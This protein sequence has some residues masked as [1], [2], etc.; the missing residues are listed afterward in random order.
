MVNKG[1][2]LGKKQTRLGKSLRWS[3]QKLCRLVRRHVAGRITWRRLRGNYSNKHAG[4]WHLILDASQRG[5]RR[6][7]LIQTKSDSTQTENKQRLRHAKL[8]T[9]RRRPAGMLGGT[10]TQRQR[11]GTSRGWIETGG[12]PQRW[13]TF[14]PF[15]VYLT[16]PINNA[17]SSTLHHHHHTVGG[18]EHGR[19]PQ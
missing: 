2:T 4:E 7:A 9:R 18:P 8:C 17:C 3:H 1:P 14:V 11:R 16:I 13:S 10:A 19:R 15:Q 5:R 12:A 6:V